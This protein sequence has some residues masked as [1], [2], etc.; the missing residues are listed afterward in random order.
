MTRKHQPE[1]FPLVPIIATIAIFCGAGALI[2][3]VV[4]ETATPGPAIESPLGVTSDAESSDLTAGLAKQSEALQELRSEMTSLSSRVDAAQ[5]TPAQVQMLADEDFV[6]LR[7]EFD[8]LSL[9]VDEC[10]R[11]LADR[12]PT[13]APRTAEPP[14]EP[15]TTTHVRLIC[16][17]TWE[18]QYCVPCKR[19]LKLDRSP[20]SILKSHRNGTDSQPFRVDLIRDDSHPDYP[21]IQFR[22][23][24]GWEDPFVIPSTARASL[25]E[26]CT[27]QCIQ[28]W[29][30]EPPPRD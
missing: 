10:E 20:F 21:R 7:H 12:E 29:G 8:N 22:G 28:R 6:A 3:H 24:N 27:Q 17:A 25:V 5:E 14:G 1:P 19:Q 15:E 4:P 13:P 11:L 9:R 18:C 16:P 26:W 23:P 30:F 2:G